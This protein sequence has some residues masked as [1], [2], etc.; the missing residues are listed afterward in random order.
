MYS[1]F[2]CVISS[3]GV[4]V[5]LYVLQALNMRPNTDV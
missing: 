1:L 2:P 5:I 4:F 3:V